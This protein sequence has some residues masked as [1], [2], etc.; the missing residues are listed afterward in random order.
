MNGNTNESG[1][2]IEVEGLSVT[3]AEKTVVD[4]ISF[5]I[6]KGEILGIVG[7][8]GSG[9]SL[10]ALSILQLCPAQAKV[11]ASGG[12][13]FYHNANT[14]TDILSL[15][16]TKLR[17]IRGNQVAMIFQEPMTSLN[18]VMK[19]G[20][21]VAEIL[22]IH[23][24]LKK[25]DIKK[26][27]L[28]L[29]REVLLPDPE[30]AY[31][32]YPHQLSGG[33]R[34]RVMIAMALACKPLLLIADEP[35]TALDVTVQKTI[36]QLL[37]NLQKKYGM[38]I[39]FIS[40]DLGVVSEICHGILVMNKG[41]IVE[42]LT[43][44]QI[45]SGMA[46]HPYTKGLLAC[47]PPSG[48][49][50]S[51]LPTITDFMNENF[52]NENNKILV[53]TK[54]SDQI[55]LEVINLSKHFPVG[56]SF[57]GKPLA[58]HKAVDDVSFYIKEG[59]TLG[60]VGES[61]CGKTTL[62]RLLLRLIERSSGQVTYSGKNIFELRG[63]KLKEFRKHAQIVFQD[64][65]SSLNPDMTIGSALTEPLKIHGLYKNQ[66]ER[67]DFVAEMLKKTGLTGDDMKKYPHQFSGGQRQRIVIARALVLQPRFLICDEA[68]SALDVSVQAQVLNLLNDLK[69]EFGLTYLF[70]SHDLSVV[71]YMSKRMMV[72]HRGKII[73]QGDAEAIFKNPLHDYTQKLI[74][75]IP[76]R[77]LISI[78]K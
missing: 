10:T 25:K 15:S 44:E 16:A 51:R 73:E 47:L 6:Q 59:E 67:R 56:K 33:Q 27:V 21:Q 66:R 55:L 78:R 75:S 20:L 31:L 29:F 46:Q 24:K 7:E 19:C 62:S 70:I 45:R 76:G 18:N 61:G 14:V 17:E 8:S 64:P 32:S 30:K 68:V 34:Q 63:K 54:C 22:N 23:T 2:L 42:E 57:T 41:N 74:E 60:L 53:E 4:Q 48:T 38:S 5:H 37:V 69:S 26:E 72:M 13:R 77:G 36:I 49:K 39:L 1:A 58:W 40:H 43:A 50:P 3:F 12:I 71:R 35:T 9:K 28:K 65:Y 52:K 11:M